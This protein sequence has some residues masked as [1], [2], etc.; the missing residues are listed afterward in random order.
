MVF[1]KEV[2]AICLAEIFG[3]AGFATFAALVPTFISEWHL[4]NTAAGWISGIYFAGYMAAVPALVSLTDRSDP[5]RIYIACTALGGIS[6]LGYALFANGFAEALVFRALAGI[7]LAGTYMPGLKVLSNLV[8]GSSQSR[9]LSFYTSSFSVGAALSFLISGQIAQWLGWRWSF[10]VASLGSA[11][12]LGIAVW[13][14]SPTKMETTSLP[15]TRLLDFR[16]VFKDAT[17]MGY[18]IAYGAHTW[19]LFGQRSWIVAFLTYSQSLQ[20]PETGWMIPA[21]VVAALVNLAGVPASIGGN[22]LAIRF[23]RVRVINAIALASAMVSC[24]LGFLAPLSHA[25]VALLCLLHGVTAYG[26]SA[27]ITAGV[28]ATASP[29]YQGATMAVHSFVGFA[30]AFLAPLVFGAVL[31]L[32]GGNTTAAWGFAFVSLGLAVAIGPLALTVL[33]KSRK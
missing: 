6:N 10:A 3:M 19:E 5:R 26:D 31:D 23:G 20:Q 7:S 8:P 2:V 22:E 33:A 25:L 29:G 27:A 16:P 21:T 13:K 1:W 15:K 12:A 28:V 24:M 18:I 4:T 32:G 11:A 17:A 14:I 30:C 9:V